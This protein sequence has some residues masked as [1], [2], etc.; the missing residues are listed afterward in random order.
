M[1]PPQED[2]KALRE[3]RDRLLYELQSVEN[4]IRRVEE[5][6]SRELSQQRHNWM[7]RNP[8]NTTLRNHLRD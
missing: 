3:Q 5:Q 6:Q 2:L 1:Y 8:E 4:R 7:L